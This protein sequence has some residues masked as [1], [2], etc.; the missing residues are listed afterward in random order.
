M[1]CGIEYCDGSARLSVVV[2]NVF[3]D[4]STQPWQSTSVRLKIHKVKQSQSFVVEAAPI[5]SEN[6][7]FIR[8]AHLS[9]HIFYHRRVT[10]TST[11]EDYE[12][13]GSLEELPWQVGPYGACPIIQ[14]GE[15][16]LTFRNFSIDKREA[17]VH[18][19]DP[20]S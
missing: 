6:F 1:K 12:I 17:T 2:C 10:S 4:W 5:D 13:S 20:N 3:S 18:H 7:Q 11:N 19:S 16:V 14:N 9:S 15:C 8:I